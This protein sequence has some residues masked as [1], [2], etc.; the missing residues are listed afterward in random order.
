MK[1]LHNTNRVEG[2][3]DAVFA[4]AATLMVVSLDLDQSFLL[5]KGKVASFLSFG[6]SFFVLV[7]LW[8]VHY[9]FFRRTDYIDN[10][11]IAY[12]AILLFV[13]LYYVFPLKSLINSWMGTEP[14]TR[15][16]LAYLFQ[17]YGAGFLCIFLC[18]SLMYRR[19]KKNTSDVES[20]KIYR[21][22]SQH[23]GIYV[24]VSG[25]S[26][27]LASLKVG[28]EIGAPGFF[29]GLLGPLCNGHAKWYG[30]K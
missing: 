25:L 8:K 10:W 13:I 28:I 18:F 20:R 5:M 15:D 21:F 16:G 12:N 22:Y 26:V 6:V 24:L 4:F 11:V 2:F 17:L 3:S 30:K 14:L 7:A 23:H 27:I 19:V 9:N 29:S 1:F